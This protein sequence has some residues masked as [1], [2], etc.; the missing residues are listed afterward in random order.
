MVTREDAVTVLEALRRTVLGNAAVLVG[1]SG[2]L[3]LDTNVPPLTEDLDIAVP[4]ELVESQGSEIVAQLADLGFSHT[5][6]TATFV[7]L[8][9]GLSLDLLGYGDPAA[10]DLVAGGEPLRVMVFADLSRLVRA[11]G[12]TRVG[13]SG[14]LHL[15]AAG[16]VAAKLLT[17]RAHK[18]LKD[19]LQALLLLAEREPD[20][21]IDA[22]LL[23]LLLAFGPER[24]D[25]A[26]ASAQ[27]AFLALAGDPAF[28]DAGAEGYAPSLAAV[29]RGLRHL[30][31]LL[32]EQRG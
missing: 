32:G 15:T 31:K 28:S 11:P 18:G 16:L 23:A 6:G 8:G 25:D 19:K 22:E 26:L 7:H 1:S 24:L 2:L 9:N 4:V 13:P 29:E 5:P 27:E 21:T 30:Q 14:T 20:G 10:G 3:D 17:E 12:A